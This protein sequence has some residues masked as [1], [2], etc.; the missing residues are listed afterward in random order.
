[1][2]NYTI[3]ASKPAKNWKPVEELISPKGLEIIDQTYKTRTCNDVTYFLLKL[4]TMFGLS[5]SADGQQDLVT[6]STSIPEPNE[7]ITVSTRDGISGDILKTKV[8][9]EILPK[10]WIPTHAKHII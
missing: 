3:Y 6:Y 8:Y 2:S 4:A 9:G 10:D 7:M 5:F 1:M